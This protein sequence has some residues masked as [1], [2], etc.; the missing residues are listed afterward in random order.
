MSTQNNQ[1]KFHVWL[2]A[3]NST[4]FCVSQLKR[5]K[6]FYKYTKSV[7]WQL[8]YVL[9]LG[10]DGFMSHNYPIFSSQSLLTQFTLCPSVLGFFGRRN[11]TVGL[12]SGWAVIWTNCS[13]SLEQGTCSTS[14]SFCSC[15][16]SFI[17]LSTPLVWRRRVSTIRRRESKIF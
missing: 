10:Q 14:H 7:C 1:E 4:L 17:A 15:C 3:L 5:I 11:G 9:S 13:K 2:H 16:I 6:I 12:T 8:F